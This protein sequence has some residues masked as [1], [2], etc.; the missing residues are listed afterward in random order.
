MGKGGKG[1][2]GKGYKGGKRWTEPAGMGTGTGTGTGVSGI[3]VISTRDIERAFDGARHS[4][5]TQGWWTT[6]AGPNADLKTSLQWLIGRHQ[7]LVDNEPYCLKAVREIVKGAVGDGVM[8]TPAG[9]GATKRVQRMWEDWAEGTRCDFYGQTNFYG[10]QI[11]AWETMVVRG[12]VL[13]RQRLREENL[14]EGM[15]PLQLQVLEPDW[16][17]MSKDDGGKIRFGKQYDDEGR[18]EG[19][20]IRRG[21]PGETDWRLSVGSD[22]VPARE[23]VHMYRIR[24]PGQAIG[25]PWGFAA[26]L[27]MRD[28][29]DRREAKLMSD[30]LA[31]CFTAF[32]VDSDPEAV[33]SEDAA[34]LVDSLEPGAVEILP[35]GKDIRFAQ[36]PVSGDYVSVDKHHLR[37]VAAAYEV[38]YEQLSGDLSEVNYSS[39]RMGRLGF[40][41]A[42][43]EWRTTILEPQ[44]LNRVSAWF[45]QSLRET[46]GMRVPTRWTWTPPRLA[47]VDPSKEVPTLVAEVLAGFRSLEDVHRSVYGSYTDEVLAQLKA[48]LEAARS[49]GLALSTDGSLAILTKGSGYQDTTPGVADTP[50]EKFFAEGEP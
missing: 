36:P 2:K 42:V 35:P 16:L 41:A 4:R 7:D 8:G 3:Q 1:G 14:L 47:M 13:V 28:L 15:A 49:Q 23:M 40:H 22:F 34:G 25:V 21:H 9:P 43:Q 24:R 17:D 44:L 30:K 10:L 26:L 27:T 31:A 5:R 18:L 12:S 48:N 45:G 29:A 6:L 33:A 39:I 46:T 20:W 50:V 37:A 38:P 32:V 19:Y 11:Q